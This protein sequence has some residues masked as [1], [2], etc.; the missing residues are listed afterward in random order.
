M[1]DSSLITFDDEF[2]VRVLDADKHSASVSLQQNCGTFDTTVDQLREASTK[3]IHI[4]EN[5]AK[6]IEAEKLRAI[7]LRNRVG[8][9]REERQ[10][11]ASEVTARKRELMKQQDA[12]EQE[13]KSLKLVIDEQ[14]AQIARLKGLSSA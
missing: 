7:G 1:V 6:N 2:R 12:L 3:Y 11:E 8:A 5:V 13:E 14:N 4:L 9:A 10:L